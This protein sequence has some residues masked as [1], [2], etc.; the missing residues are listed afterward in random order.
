MPPT[1][2]KVRAQLRLGLPAGEAT[3]G[4]PVGPG[5]G[6][7]GVNI[8]EFVRQY[9]AATQA[10]KGI[11]VPVDVTVYEDRSFT[12]VVKTP[13]AASLLL[14]AAGIEKGSSAPN[15]DKVGTV[16]REQLREIARTKLPELNARDLEAAERMAE[17]TARSMGIVVKD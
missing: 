10:Q 1:N 8:M 15:R 13:P 12:F 17:G 3:P 14:R 7:H 6:Q 5:L 11:T 9:N 4:Y 2:K 16:T